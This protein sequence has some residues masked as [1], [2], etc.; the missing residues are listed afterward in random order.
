M[1]TFRENRRKYARIDLEFPINLLQVD[2]E[3]DALGLVSDISCEG[4]GLWS[5]K[6]FS[7]GSPLEILLKIPDSERA[8]PVRGRIAW[9]KDLPDNSHRYGVRLE[10]L[11]LSTLASAMK[12]KLQYF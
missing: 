4:L 5:K 7:L 1:K 3:K 2:Q 6:S 9:A 10:N 12:L 11:D 8:I